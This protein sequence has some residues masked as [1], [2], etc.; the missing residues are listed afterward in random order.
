MT[1]IPMQRAFHVIAREGSRKSH[2]LLTDDVWHEFKNQLGIV[3]AHSELLRI[4]PG[5][6]R[7]RRDSVKE[8]HAAAERAL[9][10]L[11]LLRA[12]G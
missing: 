2:E 3:V 1:T 9:K 11:P 6:A 12:E 10:L 8:I 4:D 5:G 7:M